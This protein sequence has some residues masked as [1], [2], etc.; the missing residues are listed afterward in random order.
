M[1]II[2][3]PTFKYIINIYF[4]TELKSNSLNFHK[5]KTTFYVYGPA[6]TQDILEQKYSIIRF[7][8]F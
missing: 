7:M 4:R 3:N 1:I 6:F 2:G 8:V 5:A